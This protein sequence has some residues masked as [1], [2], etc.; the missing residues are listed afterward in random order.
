MYVIP[1]VV[2]DLPRAGS[3]WVSV[4][5]QACRGGHDLAIQAGRTADDAGLR[6][7]I[8]GDGPEPYSSPSSGPLCS[9]VVAL[10]TLL[11]SLLYMKDHGAGRLSRAV[12]CTAT[13]NGSRRSHEF[14][15]SIVEATSTH[16]VTYGHVTVSQK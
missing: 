5:S 8:S 15:V 2:C 12:P 6:H 16:I 9:T 4:G 13:K 11:W 1:I 3:P 7:R 10:E 14:S